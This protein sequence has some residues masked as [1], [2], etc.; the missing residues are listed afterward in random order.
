MEKGG[1]GT[2]EESIVTWG[3]PNRLRNM[4]NPCVIYKRFHSTRLTISLR[5]RSI[6]TPEFSLSGTGTGTFRVFF[7]DVFLHFP[8]GLTTV[9]LRQW[10]REEEVL[11]P[12]F[13][14]YL[15]KV[16]QEFTPKRNEGFGIFCESRGPGE[17]K[18]SGL[19]FFFFFSYIFLGY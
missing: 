18:S 5:I 17:D 12:K 9:V 19:T 14:L 1:R 7:S 11:H 6:F 10:S 15:S 8:F 3:T 16:V 13:S 4:Y 2:S